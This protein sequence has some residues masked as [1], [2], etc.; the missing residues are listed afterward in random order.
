MAV[1]PSGWYNLLG[2]SVEAP[3]EYQL[4]CEAM[5][6][7]K[8]EWLEN[9]EKMGDVTK[10]SYSD[11]TV[12]W[13]NHGGEAAQIEDQALKERSVRIVPGD[14]GRKPF[15]VNEDRSILDREPV[16]PRDG[17][18]WPGDCP[19]EGLIVKRGEEAKGNSGIMIGKDF[20]PAR[21]KST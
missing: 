1:E 3:V 13:V 9:I 21:G 5:K 2:R 11:G 17:D 14:R 12:V 4:L 20:I 16:T 8:T 10:T 15:A 19:R 7:L 6:F 18:I